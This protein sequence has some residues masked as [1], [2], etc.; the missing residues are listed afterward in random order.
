[1]RGVGPALILCWRLAWPRLPRFDLVLNNRN[2]PLQHPRPL[3]AFEQL[4]P[5]LSKR[6]LPITVLRFILGFIFFLDNHGHPP[7]RC[8]Y[9]ER[10]TGQ[11]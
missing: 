4:S 3:L 9:H 10:Q 1:M 8:E 11:F 2:R 5:R 7:A 6:I